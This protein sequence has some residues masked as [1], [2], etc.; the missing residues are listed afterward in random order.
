MNIKSEEDK[1]K[2]IKSRFQQMQDERNKFLPRWKEAEQYVSPSTLDWSNLDSLP[3][4]PVR[5]SSAPC[6]YLNTLTSG[7]VGYSVS[8]NIVWYKLGLEDHKLTSRYRVKDWLED[9][10]DVMN[11]EFSRSALYKQAVKFIQNAGVY[12]HGVMFIGEDLSN[13]KLHFATMKTNEIFLDTDTKGNID[14]VFRHYTM[15][16]RNCVDFFGLDSLH[17]DYKEDYKHVEKWNNKIELLFA[18]FP[19]DGFNY[20]MKDS[21]NKP[22]A[23]IYVDLKN[24]KIIN[25]SGFDELPYAVFEWENI[26]GFAYSESPSNG[27]MAEIKTLN[28]AEKTRLRIA[29]TS[30]E[31]PLIV[32][33]GIRNLNLVPKA[34]NYIESPTDRIEPI[35]TGENYPITLD[36][37]QSIKDNVKD[38]FHVDFFLMLQQKQGKMTATEVMELQGEKAAVLS[39]LIVNLNDA[40]QKIIQRSFNLLMKAGKLPPVPQ[41]LRGLGAS[42]KIDF[43]GPLSQAQKKYHTMG[44]IAQAMQLSSA[45]M[46]MFP[47]SGDYIDAD[48]LMKR[49]LEGQ[50]M[51]QS[52]IREDEDVNTIRQNRIAQQQAQQQQAQQQAILAEVMNNANKLNEPVQ[53]NSLMADLNNQVTGGIAR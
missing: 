8:P 47:N 14:T 9:V 27:A 30:A 5:F 50:G 31:P 33:A 41:S 46:Q 37:V 28:I 49:A 40:L 20:E 42:M 13:N 23:A 26:P 19:R 1:I 10:E 3:D 4:N 6:N 2:D 32:S 52:V 48:E 44:G 34:R 12:G 39:N 38:F 35:R 16:L 17:E 45:I 25:E 29:Q 24:S 53:N 7:L 18:V 36:V 15:T 22:Y 51:P 11:A 43:I 21:K